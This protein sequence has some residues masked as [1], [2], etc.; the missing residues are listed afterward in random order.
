DAFE[1]KEKR[2]SLWISGGFSFFDFF[3]TGSTPYGTPLLADRGDG[4]RDACLSSI[5]ARFPELG[6]PSGVIFITA[7]QKG[8]HVLPHFHAIKT[9]SLTAVSGVGTPRSGVS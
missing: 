6:L 4:V 1:A 7:E 8:L 3:Q 5:G 9:L 2:K